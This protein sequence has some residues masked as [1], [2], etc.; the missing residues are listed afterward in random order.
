MRHALDARGLLDVDVVTAHEFVHRRL[1][2]VLL[3]ETAQ[4]VV[5]DAL[6]HR[7][8]GDSHLLDPE[9]GKHSRHDGKAARDHRAAVVAQTG[10]LQ[11]VDMPGL[12]E[13][14]AQLRQAVGGDAAGRPPVLFEDFA[15]CPRGAG[16]PDRLL[17]AGFGKL[18]GDALDLEPGG[19]FGGFQ[20]SLVDH[21]GGEEAL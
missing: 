1:A 2:H 14:G 8:L 18:S 4:Q 13:L 20:R 17:P 11:R 6:A 7:G 5:Q 10:K 15:Q 9:L 21:S 12:D 3:V 19:D 16:R